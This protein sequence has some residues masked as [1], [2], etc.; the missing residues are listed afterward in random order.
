MKSFRL[1]RAP[2]PIPA[3][4]ATDLSPEERTRL[5]QAFR[6][7]AASYRHRHRISS[8]WLFGFAGFSVA[9]MFFGGVLH[10][11]L[12]QWLLLPALICWLVGFGLSITAPSLVCPGCGNDMTYMFGRYCPEC[13]ADDLNRARWFR[14][15]KCTACGKTLRWTKHQRYKIRARTHCGLALDEE[16][17]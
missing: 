4:L 10:V 3:Q 13:G 15:T 9:F 17:L 5:R 12:S 8:Y 6:A 2:L 1:Y 14:V 16:G 11:P 7:L